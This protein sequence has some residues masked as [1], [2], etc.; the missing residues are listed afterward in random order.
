M[1]EE[2]EDEQ[3][4]LPGE[5]PWGGLEDTCHEWGVH[6]DPDGWFLDKLVRRAMRLWQGEQIDGSALQWGVDEQG[7]LI[8]P[9]EIQSFPNAVMAGWRYL[10]SLKSAPRYLRAPMHVSLENRSWNEFHESGRGWHC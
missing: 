3:D 1:E 4:T 5:D 6:K 9:R 10:T 2:W 7:K 8:Q